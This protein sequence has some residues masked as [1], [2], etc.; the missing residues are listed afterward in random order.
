MEVKEFLE[1][2]MKKGIEE[3]IFDSPILNE[4]DILTLRDYFCKFSINAIE[5]DKTKELICK[6][7]SWSSLKSADILKIS[8]KDEFFCFVEFKEMS[9]FLKGSY[10]RG[11][12]DK[13]NPEK[14]IELKIENFHLLQKI[15]D[16]FSVFL[17]VIRLLFGENLPEVLSEFP[18]HFY[19]LTDLSSLTGLDII[20]NSLD[21]LSETSSKNNSID[22]LAFNLFDESIDK[23]KYPNILNLQKPKHLN[24]D[25]FENEFLNL[26]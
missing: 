6:M 21:F 14:S 2:L 23:L 20:A 4:I 8:P 19:F 7:N 5:F 18:K 3:K 15:E 22:N 11:S 10:N 16:S 12:I 13:N 24:C 17:E 26:N 1:Y 25:Q 9:K